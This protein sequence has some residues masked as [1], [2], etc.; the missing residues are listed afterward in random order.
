MLATN[1]PLRKERRGRTQDLARL[2]AVLVH[3]DDQRRQRVEFELGPEPG[4]EGDVDTAAVEIAGIVEDEGLELGG[5]VVEGRPA[6]EAGDAVMPGA[7]DLHADGIDAVAQA[8]VARQVHVGGGIAELAAALLAMDDDAAHEPGPAEQRGGARDV[9]TPERLAHQRRGDRLLPDGEGRHHDHGHA[10]GRAMGLQ[11]FGRTRPALA[12]MEVVAA[13]EARG[14]EPAEQQVVDEIARV[15]GGDVAVE[16]QHEGMAQSD[17][18]QQLGLD[19]GRGQPEHRL[20]GPEDAARM[21]L[22]GQ[23][24]RIAAEP[25]GKRKRLPRQFGMA[26]MDAVE[27]A[28][29]D[30]GAAQGRGHRLGEIDHEDG[31]FV[32]GGFT[33]GRRIG[34]TCHGGLASGLPGLARARLFGLKRRKP[35]SGSRGRQSDP[36]LALE[37]RLAVDEAFAEQPGP[38]PVGDEL[39]DL[40][41]GGDHV[42]D[43]HRRQEGQCLRQVDRARTRQARAEQG[44]DEAGREHAMGDA[45]AEARIGGI[46]IAEMDRVGVARNLGKKRDVALHDRAHQAV[47]LAERQVLESMDLIERLGHRIRQ[48]PGLSGVASARSAGGSDGKP[49]MG[50]SVPPLDFGTAPGQGDGKPAYDV[51]SQC[52]RVNGFE[53]RLV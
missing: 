49:L 1:A 8:A 11:H 16:G 23:G 37:H 25:G 42:A 53:T 24:R 47:A 5:A 38:A 19:R 41:A 3:L 43:L 26:A 7:V 28:D 46:A 4:D 22:E 39:D 33:L 12:E 9:A 35:S 48:K 50:P 15:D 45:L 17:A 34:G 51:A 31:R 52:Y 21:R 18:R 44:R 32:L 20:L 40:D 13:D 14:A 10:L 30:H 6:A 27:I 29:R 2:G 36:G